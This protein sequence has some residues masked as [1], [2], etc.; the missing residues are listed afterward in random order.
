LQFEY[1]LN[2]YKEA[3][4]F[5]SRISQR[6]RNFHI[7]FT[8][9]LRILKEDQC[10]KD[11]PYLHKILLTVRTSS[12]FSVFASSSS[13]SFIYNGELFFLLFVWRKWFL[14]LPYQRREIVHYCVLVNIT[15]SCA[16]I[17]FTSKY[18]TLHVLRLSYSADV[19]MNFACLPYKRMVNFTGTW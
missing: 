14:I 19:R 7:G 13:S 4:A 12:S 11:A 15:R 3:P 9:F 6:Q 18:I 5:G 10:W 16:W 17:L 8:K 1:I 2:Q